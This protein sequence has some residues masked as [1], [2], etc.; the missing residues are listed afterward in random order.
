MTI[1]LS[2]AP[3]LVNLDTRIF[4]YIEKLGE[5]IQTA[6]QAWGEFWHIYSSLADQPLYEK[7]CGCSYIDDSKKGDSRFI[8]QAGLLVASIPKNLPV[9]LKL[10]NN[11]LAGAYAKFHLQGG[12]YQLPKAYPLAFEIVS[13]LGLEIRNDFCAEVYMNSMQDTPEE[14]LE[15]EIYIPIVMKS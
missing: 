15:T 2:K 9:G 3:S 13:K 12:Y 1:N 4:L 6:P 10:R 11:A 14:N 5:F 7:M 8:Y